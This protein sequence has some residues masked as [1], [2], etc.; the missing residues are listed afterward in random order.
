MSREE[1]IDD[2]IELLRRVWKSNPEKTI[3]Q[4]AW[5]VSMKSDFMFSFVP[6]EETK[7]YLEQ[8]VSRGAFYID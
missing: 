4:I 7:L 8:A 3:N 5:K 2:M 6:D 1:Q